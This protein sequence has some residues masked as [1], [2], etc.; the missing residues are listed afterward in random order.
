MYFHYSTLLNQT[1]YMVANTRVTNDCIVLVTGSNGQLGSELQVIAKNYPQIQFIFTDID[2]LD[3]TNSKHIISFFNKY[4]PT[5]V[6]NCAA[7]TAVDAAEEDERAALL[8]NYESPKLLANVSKDFG[9]KFIHLSTDY[10]FNGNACI[11]YREDFQTSPTSVYGR[12]KLKG[13]IAAL[14][15]G[16]SI[17][18]RTSW[19]YSV[20]G[21]NFM[22]TIIRKG[23]ELGKLRVVYDQIGSPT[24]ASDLAN[25]IVGIV[26]RSKEDFAPGIYNYS[27]E[28]VCSWYD[29]AYEIV[30]KQGINCT[31]TP[32]LSSEY[33]T[34]APRPSYSVLDKSKIRSRFAITIPHW[35]DSLHKC[36]KEF[37]EIN[38]QT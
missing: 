23:V 20:F 14:E 9:A 7:Y 21:N 36:L 11:P 17:I 15:S 35:K 18:I 38:R 4:K 28:G 27:N 37:S 25:V 16:V 2:K 33:Q 1:L 19:L 12:T 29:F 3:I 13:E 26:L 5:F 22:K 24:W 8:L 31:V 6:I 30:S 32:V 34:K 10:V